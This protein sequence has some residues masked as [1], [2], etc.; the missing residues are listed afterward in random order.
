M[1][2]PKNKHSLSHVRHD[3]AHC[4]APGLFRALKRGERKR[5]KGGAFLIEANKFKAV[6]IEAASSGDTL[7]A[8]SSANLI[9]SLYLCCRLK[10]FGDVP[11]KRNSLGQVVR[12]HDNPHDYS[13]PELEPQLHLTRHSLPLSTSS[14]STPFHQTENAKTYH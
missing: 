12:R 13:L 10:I 9:E 1:V 4:L 3:P 14:K 11:R 8:P 7:L 2:K 6:F 5:G